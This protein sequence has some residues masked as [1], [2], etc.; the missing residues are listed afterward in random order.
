L[1][2]TFNKMISDKYVRIGAYLQKILPGG[3]EDCLY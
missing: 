1:G 2:I 3:F